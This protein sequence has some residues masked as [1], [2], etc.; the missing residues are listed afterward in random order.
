MPTLGHSVSRAARGMKLSGVWP[1]LAL[2]AV[3]ALSAMALRFLT[4]ATAFSPMIISIVIAILFKNL[5][6]TGEAVAPGINFT[7]KRLLRIGVA[8]LGLQITLAQI[9]DMGFGAV[10]VVTLTLALSFCFIR[11]A[12]RWLGVGEPLT[13]LIAA[14]TSVC[15]A[16]A[17]IAASPVARGSEEDVAYAVAC[18]TVMGSISMF[19]YPVL[20]PLLG[21][22][23]VGYGVW[24][25]ATIHEVAQV[26]AAAFQQSDQA[27]QSATV[28]KLSR[29]VLLAPV[30]AFL[31]FS[32]RRDGVTAGT[33]RRPPVP[34]FVV[35]FV[36]LVALNS[37]VSLPAEGLAVSALATTLLL[38]M[39]LAAMGL[40]TDLSRL[41]Q[42]GARPLA[43]GIL[44]WLFISVLGG[45]LVR[46]LGL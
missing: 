30:I 31:A 13:D 40:Q 16:S 9:I 41:W 23:D 28:A 43:L 35:A 46:L 34:W 7:L 42:K 4:G 38:C 11:W 18:V 22:G 6:G 33:A 37:G 14:G 45:L 24:T 27:G 32:R 8:L 17:V 26:T 21:F 36:G 12:G 19:L 29:V 20:A 10:L 1:G 3:I 5:L 39:A 15:G 25:G 2:C 44:G